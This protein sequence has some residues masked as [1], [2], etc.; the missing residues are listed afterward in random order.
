[1]TE[2]VSGVTR[3]RSRLDWVVSH[4]LRPGQLQEL[5]PPLRQL[6]RIGCYEL[7]ELSLPAYA[8]NEHVELAKGVMHEGCGKV[9][10]SVLRR[11]AEAVQEGKVPRPPPPP[12]GASDVQ[13]AAALA[14]AASHPQWLVERWMLRFGRAGTMAL[15][16]SNNA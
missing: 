2:I 3:W 7:V 8:I 5:D 6:L 16:Q 12:L 9:C 14:L 4:W 13:V 10:N 11:L 1:M 15:L